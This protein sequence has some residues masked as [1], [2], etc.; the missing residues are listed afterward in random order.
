MTAFKKIK[1]SKGRVGAPTK[2]TEEVLIEISKNIKAG[3]YIETA[4]VIAGVSKKTFYEWLKLSH[5]DK[6]HNDVKSI[7]HWKLCVQLRNAVARAQEEAT[8]RDIVNIDRCA[9]GRKPV[10]DRYPKGTILPARD[11]KGNVQFDKKT[12]EMI[13]IDMSDQII[14]NFKGVP[15]IAEQG[16][17]P[18]WRASAWRLEKR[19]PK[20]WGSVQVLPDEH[21]VL[22]HDPD[23]MDDDS[24][25]TIEFVDSEADKMLMEQMLKN[26]EA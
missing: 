25:I 3:A 12:G 5:K 9:M 17:P 6:N 16:T 22:E 20:E 15:I 8:M 23:E 7:T 26:D 13:M 24:V 14:C 19:K 1:K 2:L 18:D 4:V 21:G 11:D 10:Y